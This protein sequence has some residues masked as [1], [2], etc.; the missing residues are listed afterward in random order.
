LGA[1]FFDVN[2]LFPPAL[3]L[4]VRGADFFLVAVGNS[5]S[6]VKAGDSGAAG[7]GGGGAVAIFLSVKLSLIFPWLKLVSS[8]DRAILRG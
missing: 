1:N 8:F 3:I 4:F 6:K 5:S 7:G 2:G